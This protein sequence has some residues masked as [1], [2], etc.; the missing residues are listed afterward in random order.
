MMLPKTGKEARQLG[1]PRYF[2]GVEC[3][4][5]HLSERYSNGGQCVACDNL[6]EKPEEQR[7]KATKKYYES[8][9]EKCMSAT[10]KWRK[11]SGMGYEYTKRSRIKNPGVMQFANAKRHAAK[12]KRTPS[13]LNAGHWLEMESVYKY[14]SALRSIGLDYEVDHVVPMQGQSVSGLHVPWN[15]QL[16]TASENSAKGNRFC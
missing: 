2:T 8:N 5:G 16:M 1:L 14:C 7:K 6:R 10:N 9:K 12:M 15:L 13:W 3:K 4:R 11:N